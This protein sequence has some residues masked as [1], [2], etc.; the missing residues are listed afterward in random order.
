[1]YLIA[2]SAQADKDIKKGN[3]KNKAVDQ[4]PPAA[5]KLPAPNKMALEMARKERI[6]V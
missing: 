3:Q 2:S 1:M 4:K 6:T 5:D